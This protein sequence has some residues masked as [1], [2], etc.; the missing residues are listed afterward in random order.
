MNENSMQMISLNRNQTKIYK[1]LQCHC[2]IPIVITIKKATK[3]RSCIQ[4]NLLS[5]NCL[6]VHSM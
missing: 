1:N 3:V 2:L 6:S 5:D 4:I